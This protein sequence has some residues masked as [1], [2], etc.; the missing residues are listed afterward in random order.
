MGGKKIQRKILIVIEEKTKNEIKNTL[1][2]NNN[3][4][5]RKGMCIVQTI[6]VIYT[7][8]EHRLKLIFGAK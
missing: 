2:N 1:D 7:G 8:V 6:L 5:S 4:R 3:N